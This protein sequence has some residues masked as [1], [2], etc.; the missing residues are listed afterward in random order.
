[1]KFDM[2]KLMHR[3]LCLTV[4]LLLAACGGNME[5]APANTTVSVTISPAQASLWTGDTTTFRADVSGISA[6][7]V[8]WS[9]REGASGGTI[10]NQGVY[11]APGAPGTFTIEASVPVTGAPRV[12]GTASVNVS[13]RPAAGTPQALHAAAATACASMPLRTTGTTYHFC[14]CQSGADSACV[15]DAA[16]AG[17]T[18]DQRWA[19]VV[20]TFNAMNAGDTVALCRG[21]AWAVSNGPQFYNS[22]CRAAADMKAA[23]NTS[24]CDIRDYSPSW[25]GTAKPLIN[26]TTGNF[27]QFS[28]GPTQG[29]RIMNLDLRTT[30]SGWGIWLYSGSFSDFFVCNNNFDG[31]SIAWNLQGEISRVT[32]KGNRV[33]N[34]HQ[35]AFLGAA[36]DLTMDANYFSG[37]GSTNALDHTI[38]VSEQ[39]PVVTSSN[40]RIVNNE[41]YSGGAPNCLGSIIVVHGPWQTGLIDNNI[42]DGRDGAGPG[43]WGIAVAAGYAAQEFFRDFTISRNKIIG[44]GNGN[45]F[46]GEAPRT[47][48]ENNIV[49][50]NQAGFGI[51]A[52]GWAS[53]AEDD[54]TTAINIRNNTIYFPVGTT[55]S[56]IGIG[57]GYEGTNH[58]IANNSI[59]FAGSGG[60]C[61]STPL[62]AGAYSFVGNNACYNGTWGSTYDST[63]QITDD[64]LYT[65]APTDFTPLV[66]SPLVGAAA[67]SRQPALDFNGKTRRTGSA[68]DIGAIE[69]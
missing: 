15:A 19:Q 66:T 44:G 53:S 52:P 39:E 64:P 34:S 18:P 51:T 69:R 40:L 17:L 4:A 59:Y 42:V 25:G 24:T 14:D 43:C 16:Y 10:T 65:S 6:P 60:T 47:I 29:V 23:A 31:F 36:N 21:G 46:V 61:V 55:S 3:P 57:A 13:E 37:N 35:D 48:I 22:R 68:S 49:I 26:V 38:Y 63:A 32:Y 20:S 11:S 12:V 30:G 56:S 28:P 58:V 9:V 50:A 8:T 7:V 1:M 41:I 33:T 27:A 45:I 54:I 2:T 67:L 62:G 5:P